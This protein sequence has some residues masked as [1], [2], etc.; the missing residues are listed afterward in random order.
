IS[1]ARCLEHDGQ[2]FSINLVASA[3]PA[4]LCPPPNPVRSATSSS[5]TP[6]PESSNATVSRACDLDNPSVDFAA[7]GRVTPPQRWF[8][9]RQY[10]LV[11]GLGRAGANSISDDQLLWAATLAAA[12]CRCSIP[13]LVSCD[14]DGIEGAEGFGG[15]RGIAGEGRGGV[16]AGGG[17]ASCKGYSAPGSKGTACSV[18][19]QTSW[20]DQPPSEFLYLDGLT[21]L[22]LSKIKDAYCLPGRAFAPRVSTTVQQ[23]WEWTKPDPELPTPAPGILWAGMFWSKRRSDLV[24]DR[25]K[26]EEGR[27]EGV[28]GD[29]SGKAT[30]VAAAIGQGDDPRWEAVGRLLRAVGGGEETTPLWGPGEVGYKNELLPRVWRFCQPGCKARLNSFRGYGSGITGNWRLF[31]PWKQQ[32]VRLA[33]GG[34]SSASGGRLG[35]ACSRLL[36]ALVLASAIHPGTLMADL[37]AAQGPESPTA[38]AED[39]GKAT[40]DVLSADTRASIEKLCSNTGSSPITHDRIDIILR[41]LLRPRERDA[42]VITVAQSK[43]EATPR[44]VVETSTGDHE[45]LAPEPRLGWGSWRQSDAWSRPTGREASV[46]AFGVETESGM[47]KAEKEGWWAGE[48]RGRAPV[49]RLVSL[50]SLR[51][52]ECDDLR[53]MALLW[54]S[55]VRDVRLVWEDG[56]TIERMGAV[57]EV[58]GTSMLDMFD[59]GAQG[60]TGQ[61]RSVAARLRGERAWA[62]DTSSRGF[63]GRRRDRDDDESGSAVASSSTEG[64]GI[65]CIRTRGCAWSGR[66]CRC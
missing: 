53:S 38:M 29:K 11:R 66:S 28:S 16:G 1:R 42:V 40:A 4:E 56:A 6:P 7:D 19:F 14:W 60:G 30:A 27:V 45:S 35:D 18:R 23:T 39:Y 64:K 22:F 63:R 58:D 41:D 51:V 2:L 65:P 34:N 25:A 8:G 62:A 59:C 32:R 26:V 15:E 20:T 36:G 5:S 33:E 55:F 31:G 10:V 61:N 3:P 17:G 49:A 44:Q 57:P 50:L 54:M 52:A 12:S 13:V 24:P 37:G 9:L 43:E 46:E 48:G 47:E 21:D